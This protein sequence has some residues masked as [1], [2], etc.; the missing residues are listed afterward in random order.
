MARVLAAADEGRWD[1]TRDEAERL[2]ARLTGDPATEWRELCLEQAAIVRAA[3][4]ALSSNA[5]EAASALLR[6]PKGHADA[7][8]C[9][10]ALASGDLELVAALY[11]PGSALDDDQ[12][13]L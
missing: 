5:T 3:V 13:D 10:T 2:G 11:A 7:V 12:R 6:L 4:S 1:A 8:A 9:V